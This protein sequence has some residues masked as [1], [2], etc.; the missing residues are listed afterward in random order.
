MKKYSF[1]KSPK[2]REEIGPESMDKL[3]TYGGWSTY[4]LGNGACCLCGWLENSN[5]KILFSHPGEG[6]YDQPRENKVRMSWEEYEKKSYKQ[7]VLC[8]SCF[9]YFG[10]FSI[11]PNNQNMTTYIEIVTPDKFIRNMKTIQSSTVLTTTQAAN[12]LDVSNRT[13]QLWIKQG[14]FPHA[15]KL[16]PGNQQNSPFRIPLVDVEAFRRRRNTTTLQSFADHG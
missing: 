2:R 16:D 14:A 3:L 10:L 8:Q 6:P 5:I 9:Y 12:E 15:Y 7:I 1:P 13:I 11:S 4:G